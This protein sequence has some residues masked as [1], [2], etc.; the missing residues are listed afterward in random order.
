MVGVLAQVYV[1]T[2]NVMTFFSSQR[3]LKAVALDN[4][5]HILFTAEKSEAQISL[6]SVQF[7]LRELL[8]KAYVPVM[9]ASQCGL[10]QCCLP[11]HSVCLLRHDLHVKH[12]QLTVVASL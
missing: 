6:R 9:H 5:I 12:Q 10:T 4:Q 8:S 2:D 1:L 3:N 7:I 11:L